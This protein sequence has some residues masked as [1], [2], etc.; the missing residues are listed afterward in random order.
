MVTAA[1]VALQCMSASPSEDRYH[2]D[3]MCEAASFSVT[4]QLRNGRRIEIRALRPADRD[5]L[6]AAAGRTSDQSLYRRFFGVRREFTDEE[7]ASFVNIDFVDQVALVAVTREGGREV[8]V[9]GGRYIVVAPGTAELAFTVVDEFQGQGIASALLRHLTALARTAGLSRF[10][11]EVMAD[12][13]A[14]LSVLERSGLPLER[15]RESGAVHITLQ[16]VNA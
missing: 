8:L 3:A 9:G 6:L 10:I 4:E 11:A 12:N 1:C 16:I 14:M 13:T 2:A 5:A 7:V 15:R